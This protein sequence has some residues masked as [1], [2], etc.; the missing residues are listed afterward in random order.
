MTP[1]NHLPRPRRGFTLIELLV[2][3]A[4][5]AI[6]IGLLVPAVQKV[7]AAAARIS[8]GN[9]LHQLGVACHNY[10]DNHA[11]L[12]PS[13]DLLSY[14]AEIGELT[15]VQ[16]DE[17]DGDEDIGA[18]WAVYLLP[19]LEQDNLY[20]LW[21]LN[22]YPNGNSG[23]GNGYGIPYSNQTAA[24]RQGRVPGYFCPARRSAATSGLSTDGYPPGAL[25]DYAACTGTTGADWAAGMGPATGAFRLGFNG[26]GVKFAEI[27]DGTS[28]TILIGDKH[29]QLNKYGLPSNDCCT[30]NAQNINCSTRAAGVNYPLATSVN[31]T[32][33]K[34]G[35]YHT[36]SCMFVYADGSVHGLS[37]SIAPTTLQL[38]ANIADGQSIPAYE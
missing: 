29:V 8:C 32:A 12:P 30:Y 3:I 33:W 17:P 22:Y 37:F 28:N 23:A 10:H 20:K 35:S 2:V 14:P 16:A 11:A 6:L 1:R 38:L 31:D 18:T 9:N 19:F 26:L 27:M 15:N 25:G 24:A 5:I 34:F 21:N 4:I 36:N 13:R 7:R